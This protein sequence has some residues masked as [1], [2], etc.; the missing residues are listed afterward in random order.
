MEKNIAPN[1]NANKEEDGQVADQ[2]KEIRRIKEY[3]LFYMNM[4]KEGI[5]SLEG[6]AVY[7]D[8]EIARKSIPVKI[9]IVEE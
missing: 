8:G 2:G 9:Y 3:E 7:E 5:R 4:S 6:I 1:V